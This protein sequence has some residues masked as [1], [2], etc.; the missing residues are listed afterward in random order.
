MRTDGPSY[1]NSSFYRWD[2]EELLRKVLKLGWYLKSTHPGSVYSLS[3]YHKEQPRFYPWKPSFSTSFPGH[4]PIFCWATPAHMLS[5]LLCWALNEF[6]GFSI[7]QT[8]SIC[9]LPLPTKDM[10]FKVAKLGNWYVQT[11][12]A[13][14]T[15]FFSPLECFIYLKKKKLVQEADFLK[16]VF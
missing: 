3:H 1:T 13:F 4:F 8:C 15:S 16:N 5:P 14:S 7:Q 11:L 12:L 10:A 6:L 2:N 9:H